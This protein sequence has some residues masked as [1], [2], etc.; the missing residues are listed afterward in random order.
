MRYGLAVLNLALVPF[1][2]LGYCVFVARLLFR[3]VLLLGGSD[4]LLGVLV[5]AAALAGYFLAC[6]LIDDGLRLLRR[7]RVRRNG[8]ISLR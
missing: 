8:K 4:V 2:L 1:V 6:L 5:L 3:L 7:S